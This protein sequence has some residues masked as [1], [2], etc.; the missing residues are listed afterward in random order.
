LKQHVGPEQACE[1]VVV[2]PCKRAAERI[3][4]K[5]KRTHADNDRH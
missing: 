2:K 3:E 1:V 4:A 5:Q